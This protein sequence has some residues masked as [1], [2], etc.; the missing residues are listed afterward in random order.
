MQLATWQGVA[1]ALVL[2]GTAGADSEIIESDTPS[3][4]PDYARPRGRVLSED[5]LGTISRDL[6]GYRRLTRADFRA[7]EPPGQVAGNAERLGAATCAVITPLDTSRVEVRGRPD[8]V[9]EARVIGLR[10]RARMDRQCSW[11]NDAQTAQPA[12][13]VLEHEQIHFALF[14]LE[15]RRMNTEADALASRLGATGPSQ[16]AVMAT[17]TEALRRE[18]EI[19]A[20]RVIDRSLEFDE[21]TSNSHRPDRQRAWAERV[22]LELG[23]PLR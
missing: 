19:A 13:Y 18:L 15:T 6:I 12:E 21:D 2:A 17:Y 7:T 8:G 11:W 23:E 16:Q 22:S 9:F 1:L 3:E 4:L 20:R 14:E 10:F 5:E